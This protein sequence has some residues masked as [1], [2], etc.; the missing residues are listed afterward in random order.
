MSILIILCAVVVGIGKLLM[1]YSDRYQPQLEAW[2]SEEFGQPV[3]L[4]S[5]SGEWNAFGPRLTLRG[6]RLQADGQPDGGAAIAEA[7][8]DLKPLN[9]LLPGKS[10]YNFLVIGADFRLERL[11]QGGFLLSGLGISGREAGED[12]T[13]W[14]DL[15]GIGELILEDSS[16]H[17]VDQPNRVELRFTAIEA[18]LQLNNES[19]ALN[20]QASLHNAVDQRVYGD[21]DVT[22]LLTLAGQ[23]GLAEARWHVSA[24][25]LLMADLQGR[26]PD[27]PFVP[28]TG[29]VNAQLWGDWVKQRPM[30]MRGVLDLK[31]GLLEHDGQPISIE[32]LN[33]R[34]GWKYASLE[35]WRLDLNG[36]QYEDGEHAWA[37]AE[38]TLARNVPAGVGLWLGAD[39]LP[40][41]MTMHWAQN[42]MAVYQTD[43]PEVLPAAVAG[44][45]HGL[46]LVLDTEWGV[47][48]AR[49]RVDDLYVGDWSRGPE[50][51]GLQA[52][53][54]LGAGSGSVEVE[55]AGLRV[56]WPDMFGAELMLRLPACDVHLNFGERWQL[57]LQGCGLENEDIAVSGDV[58]LSGNEG[59]PAADINMLVSRGRIGSLGPYWP[60]RVMKENVV[61]WLD[62]SLLD[63]DIENGRLQIRGDLDDFP[64]T[65]GEGIFQSVARVKGVQLQYATGWPVAQQVDAVARFWGSSMRV[66][67]SVGDVGGVPVQQATA[68]IENLKAP[69]LEV[70]YLADSQLDRLLGFI[71]VSPLQQQLNTDLQRFRFSG[72]ASTRGT[73]RFP[74]GKVKGEA[75]VDGR[76]RLSQSA[77]EDPDSGISLQ[78]IKGVVN[79]SR[80]RLAGAEITA[81]FSEQPAT[82]II[83]GSASGAERFRVD[84]T[85]R[86][87]VQTLLPEFLRVKGFD[88]RRLH[89][90]GDWTV[91][92]I[93]P[94][95]TDGVPSQVMLSVSSDLQGVRLDLPA[96]LH[97][98]PQESWPVRLDYPLSGETR[99]LRLQLAQRMETLMDLTRETADGTGSADISRALIRLGSATAEMP[100]PGRVRILGDAAELNL[101]DWVDLVLDESDSALGFGGLELETLQVSAAELRFLDRH[102]TAVDVGV[103]LG[104]EDIKA[105]FSGADIDGHVV[106]V[107]A[108]G[109]SSLTAEF[110]RLVL[111]KPVGGGVDMDTNP[112]ELP[113]LHLYAR[114]FK[115]MGIEMGETRIEAYPTA[116]GFHFE[117]VESES[118]ELSVRAS[119]DW[120]LDEAGQRSDFKIVVTAE[121]LGRFLQ[122]MDISSSLEGGQTVLH[123]TAWWPGSPGNFALS[124]LNGE[125]EFSVTR[126]QITNASSGTGRIL[127]L[128]SIQA[129]PRRLALDFRDVFDAGFDFEEAHGTFL[130][131]NGMASTDDVSL[132]SSAASITLTGSTDLVAQQ[133]DQLMTVRPGVGNT[134]P[135]IGA[136]AGGPGGAAA[137]LALQGLLHG[138]LG[139]AAQVQYT[140]TGSWDEPL[141]E[142]VLGTTTDG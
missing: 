104:D 107:P 97:K 100:P 28:L 4:E 122:S 22:A 11:E 41:D 68:T 23:A 137:G 75:Q 38:A 82:L 10:L 70:N 69:W 92:V 117:T 139:E 121:S 120:L 43:W 134:L 14:R 7:A 141:I 88:Q 78:Q 65:A 118:D 140:I 64:F 6:M 133:Y 45:V 67:G 83:S 93:V 110:E 112:A 119:G 37:T 138:Q 49:G 40:L 113:A 35:D 71:P 29:A 114:S 42:I 128:L 20:M 13:K 9:M 105:Q 132:S 36:L 103:S 62:R 72:P 50:L 126:G 27:N 30:L 32:H 31:N 46:D 2:L 17:Y 60:Q 58:L 59:R 108:A 111:A 34:F 98:T 127:G 87:E 53:V 125:V 77:F 24:R 3:T 94:P 101:D 16:L 55:S 52:R 116:S 131:E 95:A 89:G 47:R 96:P 86:F 73:L 85:G 48:L 19:V 63:G 130:M 18:R 33:T 57:A 44:E 54:D 12:V 79:Y 84:M 109:S 8:V 106:Y 25:E 1:P 66:E 102:F 74:L 123:F 129:L 91:A 56:N 99:R 76:L 61:N 26:L 115:Y 21:L 90:A 80:T 5:F 81:Q 135:V 142:P 136:I 51:D 15:L 39:H 124:R